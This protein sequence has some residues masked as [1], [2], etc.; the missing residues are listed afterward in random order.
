M[1]TPQ[2]LAQPEPEPEPQLEAA[3]ADADAEAEASEDADL[4]KQA[5]FLRMCALHQ[6]IPIDDVYV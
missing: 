5:R 6:A 4:E 2:G 1:A 3:G